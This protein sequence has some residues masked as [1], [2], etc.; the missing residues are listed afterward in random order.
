MTPERC[1]AS[2]RPGVL[3]LGG[4]HVECPRTLRRA[5][6]IGLSGW[7]FYVT[8]RGGALGDVDAATVAAAIGFVAPDAV[9]DGW[10]SA[11]LVARPAE[12]AAS[13]LAECCRW[14]VERLSGYPEVPRLVELAGRVVTAADPSGMSLFA[15]WRAAPVPDDA[16]AA[17]AAGLLYILRELVGGAYL[18]A[19]RAAGMSPIEA[20]VAGPDGEAGAAAHGWQP[21]YPA[22]GPLVRRRLWAEAVGDRIVA[23]ALTVLDPTERAEL[24]SVL[25]AVQDRLRSMQAVG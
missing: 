16:P 7:A 24:V 14:G 8:G 6:L 17:R 5:R 25:G 18:M 12:V 11:G 21:P 3:A 2:A 13:N 10:V 22:A 1:A 23:R 15:A 20:L 4:A 9:E 19:V